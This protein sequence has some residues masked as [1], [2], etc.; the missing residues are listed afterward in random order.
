MGIE[1]VGEQKS[2]NC[3]PGG[4][5]LQYLVHPDA[6]EHTQVEKSFQLGIFTVGTKTVVTAQH[7]N[8][9]HKNF[10]P[11]WTPRALV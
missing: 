3:G 2:A 7:E 5:N 11:F 9:C 10:G 4:A 8:R 6:Q 1:K